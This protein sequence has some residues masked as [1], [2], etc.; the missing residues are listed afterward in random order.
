MS[1]VLQQISSS[2]MIAVKISYVNLVI[3]LFINKLY[4]G[5]LNCIYVYLVI[6]FSIIYYKFEFNLNCG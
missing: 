5:T 3:V 6:Y 1:I 2:V 4:Q